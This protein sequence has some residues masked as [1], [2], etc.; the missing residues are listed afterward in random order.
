MEVREKLWR[1][2]ATSSCRRRSGEKGSWS[3]RAQTASMRGEEL[4]RVSS[5]EGRGAGAG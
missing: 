2:G 1:L 3:R 4:K 5:W